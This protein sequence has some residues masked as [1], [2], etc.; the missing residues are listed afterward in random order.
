MKLLLDTHAFLWFVTGDPRMTH[1]VKTLCERDDTDLFLSTASVWEMAI[2]SS[3]GKLA[4][5][6]TVEEYIANKIMEGFKI[7]AV[8]WEDAAAVENLPL[9]HR[10]PF[11]RLLAAQARRGDF[12]LVTSDAV[13]KRYG[14]K[15]IW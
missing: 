10:D 4:L 5:G 15:T 8:E 11:D 14:A 2:K 12:I 6:K 7:L 9:H 3:L 13:F 1:K